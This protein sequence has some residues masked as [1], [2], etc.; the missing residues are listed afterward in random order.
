MVS[1]AIALTD[2]L[3]FGNNRNAT[4]PSSKRGLCWLKKP[5]YKSRD[6]AGFSDGWDRML[7]Q[8]GGVHLGLF[9][10]EGFIFSF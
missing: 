9:L 5:N 2:S 7:T 10:H 4:Y 1:S 6:G 3:S 8:A